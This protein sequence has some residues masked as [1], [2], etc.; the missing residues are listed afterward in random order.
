M[1]EPK[2]HSIGEGV[3]AT[4]GAVSGMMVGSAVAG[5]VGAVVGVAV[6]AIAGGLAGHAVAEAIDPEVE[7][8]YWR[9]TYATRPYV[10]D[11]AEYHV[12]RD[13]YRYGWES[14]GR[15]Q[16]TWHDVVHEL[17]AD[18]DRDKAASSLDWAD[19]KEAVRDG[20]SRVERT[21]P[22]DSDHDAARSA[23]RRGGASR[24]SDRRTGPPA[25]A[26]AAAGADRRR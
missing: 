11:G 7:D 16:G 22:D 6:G 8:A 15:L 20:W 1:P 4:G 21:L 17:E 19:A 13:A 9:D 12:Y 23:S 18:W 14:R 3:G 25:T 10:T 2:D 24:L 26:R 5:P